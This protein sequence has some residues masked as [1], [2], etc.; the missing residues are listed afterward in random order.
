MFCY[1][2]GQFLQAA[3]MTA[4]KTLEFPTLE[5]VREAIANRP[6][7]MELEEVAEKCDVSLSWLNQVI[8]GAIEAPSYTKIVAVYRYV[9]AQ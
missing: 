7:R 9:T 2:A 6:R 3:I 1:G 5:Q 8:R 4:D